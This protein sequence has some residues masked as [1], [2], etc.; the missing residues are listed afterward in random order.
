MAA[1]AS[2]TSTTPNHRTWNSTFN[3]DLDAATATANAAA[4]TIEYSVL[5]RCP[6]RREYILGTLDSAGTI[7]IQTTSDDGATW[8]ARGSCST[9]QGT[10]NDAFG[11]LDIAYEQSSGEALIVFEN[12]TGNNKLIRYDRWDG[13]T[14]TS[15]STLTITGGNT[16]TRW[17][18]LKSL[19]G[20]DRI[21]LAVAGANSTLNV[22]VWNGSTWEST[23]TS[24]TASLAAVTVRAFD[25][26]F[27]Q[28]TG[29]ILVVY[30]SGTTL[31]HHTCPAPAACTWSGATSNSPFNPGVAVNWV[32]MAADPATD[33]IALIAHMN[34][35]G[36]TTATC[37]AQHDLWTGAGWVGGTTA[38]TSVNVT[39]ASSPNIPVAVAWEKS[40]STA[41][42]AFVDG[43]STTA[44]DYVTAAGCSGGC[45]W[46]PATGTNLTNASTTTQT[47]PGAIPTVQLVGSPNENQIY[48]LAESVDT[49]APADYE[50]QA[51]LWSGGAFSQTATQSQVSIDVDS[52]AFA[53]FSFAWSYPFFQQ[54]NYQWFLNQ[55][56]PVLNPA[57]PGDQLAT[58]NNVATGVY[59]TR[60]VRLR[61]NFTARGGTLA[62]GKI[63]RLQYSSDA[64]SCTTGTWTDIGSTETT[65][66]IWRVIGSGGVLTD[67]TSVTAQRV[68]GSTLNGL[69]TESGDST[70]AASYS[71]GDTPEWDWSFTNFQAPPNTGY[72]FRMLEVV[73]GTPTVTGS[74]SSNCPQLST[75]DPDG[76]VAY[77]T[78][79]GAN[80]PKYKNWTGTQFDASE[81]DAGTQTSTIRYVVQKTAKVASNL[82]LMGTLDSTGAITFR[83][84]NGASWA[85]PGGSCTCSTS[86]ANSAYRGFDI[87]FESK[88][89]EGLIVCDDG[90]A[91]DSVNYCTTTAGGATLSNAGSLTVS[92]GSANANWIRLE[93]SPAADYIVMGV[94]NSNTTATGAVWNG[95]SWVTNTTFSDT[96]S[97]ATNEAFDVAW[98]RVTS[99]AMIAY[100]TGTSTNYS[101]W[102]SG[103]WGTP[104]A[105]GNPGAAVSWLQLD[106]S[107][108]SDYILEVTVDGGSD[109]ETFAWS[110]SAWSTPGSCADAAASLLANRSIDVKWE[111][112]SSDAL[113]AYVDAAGGGG[114]DKVTYWTYTEGG[115]CAAAATIGTFTDVQTVQ[116]RNSPDGDEIMLLALDSTSAIKGFI[117]SG[118]AFSTPTGS[119]LTAAAS[120]AAY[121][122]FMYAWNAGAPTL[123]ELVSFGGYSR[124]RGLQPASDGPV[125]AGFMPAS[126]DA[127][128]KGAATS[129]GG[130]EVVL[131]WETAAERSNAGFY[132]H[133]S[134][135]RDAGRK[136]QVNQKMI[137]GLGTSARGKKYVF[138]DDLSDLITHH[139]SPITIQYWLEDVE[140][141]GTRTMHGPVEVHVGLDSDGD[142]MPDDWERAYGCASA[143][144]RSAIRRGGSS[145]PPSWGDRR[146]ASLDA[147]S[148]GGSKDPPLQCLDPLVADADGD[149]DGDGIS[150]LL[151]YLN[152]TSPTA[153]ESG[154]WI[155]DLSAFKS[156]GQ[157]SG[158]R[159]QELG[160][161]NQEPPAHPEPV[162][163]W[164][165]T[166]EDSTGIEM[167]CTG[168]GCSTPARLAVPPGAKLHDSPGV[169]AIAEGIFRD[170]TILR[171]ASA[172]K[173]VTGIL[174]ARLEFAGPHVPVAAG[175]SLRPERT[176]K[177]A[178]T[179]DLTSLLD[180]VV[181]NKF[182]WAFVSRGA[183]L[184]APF[185]A[186]GSKDPPL[187]GGEWRSP[188]R[189]TGTSLKVSVT[190]TGVYKITRDD[191][192][193]AGLD[194][195]LFDPEKAQVWVPGSLFLV[196]GGERLQPVNVQ[197]DGG[198]LYFLGEPADSKYTRT[199]AYWLL[200]D[201]SNVERRTSNEIL[202]LTQPGPAD[203][204]FQDALRLDPSACVLRPAPSRM[205]QVPREGRSPERPSCALLYWQEMPGP[206]DAERFFFAPVLKDGD[207]HDY[208]F[209]LPE[210]ASNEQRA[211]SNLQVGLTLLGLAESNVAQSHKVEV[212][213]NGLT[214]GEMTWT[215]RD[216]FHSSLRTSHSALRTGQNTMTLKVLLAEG[217]QFDQVLL[218]GAT[219]PYYRPSR[220]ALPVVNP[221]LITHYASR[222]LL[223]AT[224]RADYI[225]IL[226]EAG[227]GKSVGAGLQTRPEG[228]SEDAPLQE[229]LR[230]LVEYHESHG[231]T[232]KV[233]SLDQIYDE[234][235]AGLATPHA[236]KNF[237]HFAFHNWQSPK[238]SYVLLV[239]DASY[240]Y[241]GYEDGEQVPGPSFLV[242]SYLLYTPLGGEVPSDAWFVSFDGGAPFDKLRVSGEQ[243]ARGELVEPRGNEID[244]FPDM[245]IGRLPART[246]DE[247][248]AMVDKILHYADD[249][250]ESNWR[251]NVLLVADNF[252]SD[253]EG[254]SESLFDLAPPSLLLTRG[255]LSLLPSASDLSG[256]IVK[257]INSGA[258]LINYLGHGSAE[259]WAAE[260]V[261][262]SAQLPALENLGR[263]PFIS[264]L[265]CINGYF[266]FPP[267]QEFEAMAEEFVRAPGKGAVA[268]FAPS[269]MSSPAV[270]GALNRALYKAITQDRVN[271][272]G[273]AIQKAYLD[274]A[275]QVSAGRWEYVPQMFVLFGDPAMD[276]VLPTSDAPA[277]HDA[278]R[279]TDDSGC[280]CAHIG[281]PAG[282]AGGLTG[283]FGLLGL[284]AVTRILRRR[285][286]RSWPKCKFMRM[287]GFANGGADPEGPATE[288]KSCSRAFRLGKSTRTMRCAGT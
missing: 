231:L 261:F 268:F 206:S 201:P 28:S 278:Q 245:A 35:T 226:P 159:G 214:L 236:I 199:N 43:S 86:A 212:S 145:D 60:E 170:Q 266:V 260:K 24:L 288:L 136:T 116:L 109:V 197:A 50:L 131:E 246:P 85:A 249:D 255:Y 251:R 243:T 237:L 271:P 265:T 180:S 208:E 99:R 67:E 26:E 38:D 216:L 142:G 148:L 205:E 128:V 49:A 242:P 186:G 9:C 140:F 282:W 104:A 230:P 121:E 240:D 156:R 137:Q 280:G 227:V 95:S 10:T 273:A 217:A 93:A 71:L 117:W 125:G 84:W 2:G 76:L 178:A 4:G 188:S 34:G 184:D 166:K 225:M 8:T 174:R 264:T 244:L 263:Y 78:T 54:A 182:R 98:H 123:V 157:G 124:S 272:I 209:E 55:S 146:G 64:T 102:Q 112:V 97:S 63:L 56:T 164:R 176:L 262:G 134:E 153:I 68:D 220:L 147:P 276:L 187:Q 83:Y 27:E 113:I 20:S 154:V 96:T 74:Y 87:A 211:T 132:L 51:L 138:V 204:P 179:P 158:A 253:F 283:F 3:N 5:R 79:S 106:A 61:V 11:G 90:T 82:K 189:S 16:T 248:S 58:D 270:H 274:V 32:E 152:G 155:T 69:Y 213:L 167:E 65:N 169:D 41:L 30:G 110:G 105:A 44:V 14:Y 13:T 150:N 198:A 210:L 130:Y 277:T 195:N 173:E 25:I 39:S 233:V 21:A 285:R 70:T 235:G 62:S 258:S 129:A 107:H 135:T 42:F 31:S 193:D 103:T 80:E 252:Q 218:K 200:L 161:R 192:A 92:T 127:P 75:T 190:E 108:V 139:S 73:G 215:G 151:E 194:P 40:S 257:E 120:A 12:A 232:V 22:S 88:S 133:R 238:P 91:N 52:N 94:L 17:V 66:M 196:P 207:S 114:N 287:C 6:V 72:R 143:L 47:W 115:S 46:T 59:T 19:A 149:A 228:A 177:G 224:N 101:I 141:N 81:S 223:D 160:T 100:G 29:D 122:P 250:P 168:E 275:S 219:I 7:T 279:T 111:T 239:G 281:A 126:E 23:S 1:F 37:R 181:L 162:E 45:T 144:G 267:E 221:S 202:D 172:D 165:V 163:G 241:K 53:P 254:V 229:A 256:A 15:A 118:S 57:D 33:D 89:G 183:S 175:F 203:E 36:C 191:I 119:A 234:F 286:R 222:G 77:A 247:L 18:R 284:Y 269:G 259:F 171:I 48:L 185:N